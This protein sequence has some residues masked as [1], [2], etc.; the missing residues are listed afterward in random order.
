MKIRH[1]AATAALALSTL[2]GSVAHDINRAGAGTQTWPVTGTGDSIL[3][4]AY[5]NRTGSVVIL[6]SVRWLNFESGRAAFDYGQTGAGTTWSIAKL[7]IER[8]VPGGRIVIQDNGIDA[9]EWEWLTLMQRIVAATPDD[10]WIIGVIPAFRADIEPAACRCD[11]VAMA[12]RSRARAETMATML[13]Q[14]PRIRFV[15][16]ASIMAQHPNDFLDG[17]HPRTDQAQNAIQIAIGV[18]RF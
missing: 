2:I 10:R 6:D 17:Q 8:S 15:Y 12:A 14:H 5:G 18:G 4:L 3:T 16:M 11:P 7:A 1:L 9:S 13:R